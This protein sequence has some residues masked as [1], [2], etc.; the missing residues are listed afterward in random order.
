MTHHLMDDKIVVGLDIGSTKVCAVAGR[1]SRGSNNQLTLEVLGV[2]RASSEGVTKGKVM[3]ITRTV[4]AIN[5]AIEEVSNQSNVD[6][7]LVNVSFSNHNINSQKQPGSITRLSPGDEVTPADI[8][9]LLR[10]MYRT[11][12][13]A[14]KEI[15][16]VLPMDFTVDSE[17]GV[18]DPVGRNGV[19]LGADFQIITTQSDAAVNVRRC[20]ERT[21]GH[22]QRDQVLLSPLASAMAVLTPEEREAGVALVDI[23]G[24]TTDL[25]IY[26]RNVLR[27]VAVFPW[28]GNSLTNDIQEGC[29]VL[30][31]QAEVLKTKFGNANPST[32]RLNEVVSVPG[33]PGRQPKDVLLK[34]VSIIIAERLKEIAALVQAE[35]IRSGYK[36]KLL[37]GI[38]LTGGS[39]LI[40]GIDDIFQGVTDMDVRVGY[41]EQLEH[42]LRADLVSDPAFATAVGLVWAGFRSVDDRISFIS[43]PGQ[44]FGTTV[45]PVRQPDPQRPTTRTNHTGQPAARP[46]EEAPNGS[47]SLLGWVKKLF[48]PNL[49]DVN[50][51]YKE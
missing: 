2:S 35:V 46:K 44:S 8:D 20:I 50:D 39:A 49:G 43:D 4:A 5:Q 37:G 3:N 19:K 17:S 16:H 15:V 21:A 14:G 1:M 36:D 29:K 23:G 18:E 47:G 27:H 25:A 22:L 51:T 11:P 40:E 41:P 13:S 6:I 33:L 28:A 7:G 32:Y 30:P 12:Q 45:A 34:N 42:N 31:Q 38:V 48:N 26:Y 9:H 10:D 24:G